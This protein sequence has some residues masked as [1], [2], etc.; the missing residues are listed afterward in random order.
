MSLF[1]DFFSS[2][3]F[4]VLVTSFILLLGRVSEVIWIKQDVSCTSCHHLSPEVGGG[5]VGTMMH[6]H[7]LPSLPAEQSSIMKQSGPFTDSAPLSFVPLHHGLPPCAVWPL[8][9]HLCPS[10]P[11]SFT[12][13]FTC[14]LSFLLLFF[15]L[16]K[17]LSF[18]PFRQWSMQ[19]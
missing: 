8:S 13:L 17:L 18:P 7:Q 10:A 11:H 12:A 5:P 15:F 1:W 4:K 16:F 6:V 3:L 19:V 2:D 9:F 14:L